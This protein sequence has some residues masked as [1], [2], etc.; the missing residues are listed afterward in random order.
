[1]TGR[2]NNTALGQVL[3]QQRPPELKLLRAQSRG[4]YLSMRSIENVGE[5][6]RL[7]SLQINLITMSRDM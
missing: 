1:M 7:V 6:Y 5:V 3:H 4:N 2:D